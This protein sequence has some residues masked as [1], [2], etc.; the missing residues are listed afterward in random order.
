MEFA[1]EQ[2]SQAKHCLPIRLCNVSLGVQQVVNAIHYAAGHRCR[3]AYEV[4]QLADDLH[5]TETVSLDFSSTK[6]TPMA[7]A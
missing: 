3:L 5:K 6:F 7:P 1:L 2:F 4:R